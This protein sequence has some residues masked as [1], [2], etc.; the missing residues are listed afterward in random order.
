MKRNLRVGEGYALTQY[1]LKKRYIR[2]ISLLAVLTSMCL[3]AVK[4]VSAQGAEPAATAVTNIKP[5][6]IGD[7]VP[8]FL[9]HLPLLVVNHPGEKKAITLNDYRGKLIILDFWATWCV[10]CV[11]SLGKLDSLQGRFIDDIAVVPITDEDS[12][13]AASF[14]EKREW[15][16]PT[17][18]DGSILKQYF[19]HKSIPHQVWLKDGCVF[20]IPLPEY[21][22]GEVIASVIN[23]E[24]VR[25]P[26]NE[27]V[28]LD[29]SK[30]LFLGGN[31]GD[32]S[33]MLYYSAVSKRIKP[34]IGGGG[35]KNETSDNKVLFINV[36]ADYLLFAAFSKEIDMDRRRVVWEVDSSLYNKI[37]GTG[38]SDPIGNYK[39]DSAY[40]R[41]LDENLFCYNLFAVR[42]LGA[43]QVRE[44]MKNDLNNHFGAYYGIEADVERRNVPCLVL[45]QTGQSSLLESEGGDLVIE[46]NDPRRYHCT[47]APFETVITQMLSGVEP[48]RLFVDYT[49]MGSKRVDISLPT[50][51]N[52]NL[53]QAQRELSRYGLQLSKEDILLDMLV[54]KE[55]NSK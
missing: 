1:N 18:T 38:L 15:S 6:Q 25:I 53:I 31:G 34:R 54:I 17:A 45:R 50:S 40:Y 41:W 26:M 33:E 2:Y 16:L 43:S 4:Q 12:Q 9:W 20:A 51:I 35:F 14:F 8:E 3:Y 49:G 13:K 46:L 30:P 23:S 11:K 28:P 37:Q 22:N 36:S 24:P 7:T 55:H 39:A 32:G 42:K 21:A 19:P 29:K 47:N 10:P 48:N 27:Y 5:L 44:I 52:G